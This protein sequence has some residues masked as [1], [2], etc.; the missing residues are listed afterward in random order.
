V[1]TIGRLLSLV[2]GH[3]RAIASGALLGFLAVGSNIGLMAMSAYLISRAAVVTNVAD[4]ALAITAVRVLAIVRGA[5]RYF[6]RLVTH[7]ATFAILADLRVWFFASIE[8]LA[9]ARLAGERSGDLLARIVADI[10]TL[11][12]FYVRVIVPPVV[13]ALVTVFA[14]LLLGLFD[15]A[16]GFALVFF[17]VLTGVVLP[18]VSGRLS[19]RPAETLIATRAELS[20]MV[21]DEVQG[22]ADLIALDRAAAHRER[23]L[24]LGAA[25]DRATGRL[26][27]VRAGTAA[28]AATLA[29][30]AGVT[31]LAIGV[32]LVSVGRLDGVYLAI[33]P[34]VAV[35][36][37]EVIAPLSQAS[38]LLA[39]NEAAAGR[40]FEL[41]DTAPEV[42]DLPA[43]APGGTVA[44]AKARTMPEPAAP[45]AAPTPPGIEIHGLRFRYGVD[46]PLVL[47]GLDLSVPSGGSLAIVG[48]SGS[49]KS[50]L[51]NLLLRFWEY[52]AGEI[53]IGGRELRACRVDDV[54]AML[55]VVPQDVHLFNATIRDNLAVA[56]ADVTDERIIAACGMARIHEFIET[57]PAGYGTRVGEDGVLLSGGE[58][59]RL[60]IA[61]AII[62]GAPVLVLDEATANLDVV[63][64]RELMASLAPFMAGRTTIV[65]SHRASV[66]GGMD[67]TLVMGD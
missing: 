43:S 26:A 42:V 15:P 45:A 47:D 34:L 10:E 2:T 33:L 41:I 56:D 60:G 59:Q 61:R 8:P 12:D 4:V 51:V 65:I 24:V 11:E 3:R 66:A 62:K 36:S 38:G 55:G 53:R 37:F 58:R 6:E 21:V 49:G 67:R 44:V 5:F 31:V 23:V 7:R 9:P 52:E 40:L 29:G 1:T 25:L 32:Q 19:R 22:I 30:L 20:A 35:A 64:E 13:A 16:L 57:L 17:L 18:L 46:E 28:L 39:A 63:T 54:R 14:G 48:P 50:T 27:L